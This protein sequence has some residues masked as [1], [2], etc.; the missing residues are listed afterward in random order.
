M[1]RK[2]TLGERKIKA[3]LKHGSYFYDYSQ[4][5]DVT[6]KTY[7]TSVC[8]KHGE[9]VTRIDRHCNEGRRC[10][11]CADE[12]NAEKQTH[13]IGYCKA[14]AILVHGSRNYDY[15]KW[16][17]GKIKNK[18][19]VTTICPEHGGFTQ[20]LAAHLTGR[21]CGKCAHVTR[22]VSKIKSTGEYKVLAI[23]AHGDKFYDYSLVPNKSKKKQKVK[24]VCPKHG[25]FLQSLDSHISKS[26]NCPSCVTN[27]YDV[28]KKGYLY[29]LTNDEGS[30][31]VGISNVPHSRLKVLRRDTPFNFEV[32]AIFRGKGSDVRN[33]E[34]AFHN[35][36]EPTGYKGFGGATEWLNMNHFG[37]IEFLTNLFDLKPYSYQKT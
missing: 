21:S 18:T 31:K 14:R 13:T 7:V 29:L 19:V 25:T 15:S 16:G 20:K 9:F 11:K 33:C 36:F 8:P 6:D 24:I 22:K 26:A 32:L 30:V 37:L 35:N 17:S 4:W 28:N 3:I 12:D 34:K 2:Q 1:S 27:G 10:R 5:R 23:L